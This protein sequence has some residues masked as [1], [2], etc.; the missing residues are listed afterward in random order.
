MTPFPRRP[1]EP[2]LTQQMPRPQPGSGTRLTANAAGF[3]ISVPGGSKTFAHPFQAMLSGGQLR[4]RRGLV[5]TFEPKIGSVP[6]SGDATHPQPA[7]I[8]NPAVATAAGE[9]WACLEVEP[10][11][12]GFLNKASRI[13]IVHSREPVSRLKSVGRCPLALIVWRDK[14]P[15]FAVDIVYFNLRYVRV[16]KEA[17]AGPVQHF[18]L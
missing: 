18:F 6:M 11:A 15:L 8:L 9:S 7:L 4:L 1:S 14:Q 12:D 2:T 13:E 17:G 3:S 16:L 5:D 10:D